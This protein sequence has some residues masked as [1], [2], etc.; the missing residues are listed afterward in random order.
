VYDIKLLLYMFDVA[1]AACIN[2]FTFYELDSLNLLR[3]VG[4]LHLVHFK[5]PVRVEQSVQASKASDR[6]V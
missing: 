2:T 4:W 5:S 6:T 3:A 1:P